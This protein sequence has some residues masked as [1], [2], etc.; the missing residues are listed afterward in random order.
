MHFTFP[1]TN[2]KPQAA[3]PPAF[4]QHEVYANPVEVRELLVK[5]VGIAGAEHDEHVK[6]CPVPNCGTSIRL[7]AVASFYSGM[8]QAID[9]L[10]YGRDLAMLA[11][12]SR[13]V[14]TAGPG[15]AT[16][17]QPRSES[18]AT[19]QQPGPDAVLLTT[20]QL[21]MLAKD[22]LPGMASR[23]RISE[24]IFTAILPPNLRS[25]FKL[26]WNATSEFSSL[27]GMFRAAQ[28]VDGEPVELKYI[29]AAVRSR[30][31]ELSRQ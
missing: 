5:L 6:H 3:P 18:S 31:L 11:D 2:D 28:M 24:Q 29:P 16:A 26:I 15:A 8:I 14:A 10:L 30:A 7:Q 27:D 13:K 17:Q 4:M 23:L 1:T 20:E 12:A 21:L 22:N 25:S 9:I 19:A